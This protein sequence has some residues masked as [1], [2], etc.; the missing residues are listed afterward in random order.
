MGAHSTGRIRKEGPVEREAL[1]EELLVII[2]LQTL[3]LL[4][5]N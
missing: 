5:L 2:N 4:V 1:W 3:A